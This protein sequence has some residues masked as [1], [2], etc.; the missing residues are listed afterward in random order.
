VKIS[1]NSA[2]PSNSV[3]DVIE[4][5]YCVSAAEEPDD[6]LSSSM[7]VEDPMDDG[8]LESLACD[9]SILAPCLDDGDAELE[10]FLMDAV[11]WL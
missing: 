8:F 9:D 11:E 10:D 4:P 6:V 1:G 3:S 7:D 5:D 2:A